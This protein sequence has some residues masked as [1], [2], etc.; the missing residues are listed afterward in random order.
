MSRTSRF[1]LLAVGL[2]LAA[3]VIWHSG[4]AALW[5]G[6]KATGW[7]IPI[8]V[9]LWGLA[10]LGNTI[11]WRLLVPADAPPIPHSAMPT[12]CLRSC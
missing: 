1:A 8:I 12:A 11:A 10:Y 9:A 5:A 7:V 4:P 6:V 3:F 2:A